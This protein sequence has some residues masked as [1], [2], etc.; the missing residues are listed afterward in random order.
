M[1]Y[2]L[3]ILSENEVQI[4][5]LK[6]KPQWESDPIFETE[7]TLK[8]YLYDYVSVSRPVDEICELLNSSPM[9]TWQTFA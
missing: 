9:E 8:K 4:R 7:D 1:V 5:K 2:E 3:Q 6:E